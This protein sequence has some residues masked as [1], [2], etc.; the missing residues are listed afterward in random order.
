MSKYGC[1]SI[2]EDNENLIKLTFYK[3]VMVLSVSSRHTSFFFFSFKELQ[4]FYY[5]EIKKLRLRK[6]HKIV[7]YIIYRLFVIQQL[8]IKNSCILF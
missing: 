6:S 7:N 4:K 3:K 5:Y 8:L 2:L 1:W